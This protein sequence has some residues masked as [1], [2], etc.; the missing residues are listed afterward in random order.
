M[1]KREKEG[2]RFQ[3]HM[4]TFEEM[5]VR[6]MG[7]EGG[8]LKIERKEEKSRR[9]WFCRCHR[10]EENEKQVLRDI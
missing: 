2:G 7:R 1:L 8:L 3:S 9:K 6:L 10:L 4:E 5:L